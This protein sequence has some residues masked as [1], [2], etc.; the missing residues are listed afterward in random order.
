MMHASARDIVRNAVQVWTASPMQA[1][2]LTCPFF[3]V[4]FGGARGGGK[5]DA[6]LGDFLS[7]QAIYGKHAVGLV[8]RRERTQLIETIQRGAAIYELVGARW[9]DK[10]KCFQFP[11]GARLYFGYLE[12]DTDAEVYQGWS[13]TRVYVE[14]MGNFRA[15]APIAKLFATLRSPAGVPCRFRATAN[16]GGAGHGWIK[17]RFIDP[18]PSGNRRI[19]EKLINPLTGA[20]IERDRAY[21]PS[22]VT[23]NPHLGDD[24]VANLML[25]G[26][27]SAALVKAWLEGDWSAIEGAFFSEWAASRHVV[28][29]FT[30]PPHWAR[31]RAIDWG[32]ARPFSVGWYAIVSETTDLGD[33]RVMPRGSIIRYREWYG[34]RQSNGITMPNDGLRLPANEVAKQVAAMSEGEKIAYTVIDPATFA[35][36]GGQTIAEAFNING[37]PVLP[38][39]NTR[40]S[41]R[42]AMSGWNNCRRRL[43]GDDGAPTFY[44]FSTCREFI[45]TVPVLQHDRNKAEDLDSE[46]EDHAADEW[47]YAMA[48]RPWVA[49]TP[50]TKPKPMRS[51]METPIEELFRMSGR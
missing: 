17:T 46:A 47:R 44:V 13:L 48:S 8:L 12:R 26:A 34:A 41:Q 31:F 19:V 36:T 14:E 28:A 5:T 4:L 18:H 6:V 11:N 38:A 9:L 25:S 37:V 21:V 39:D 50:D 45:R 27:G 23:D 51:V 33:G 40:V 30:I 7:H 49:K 42:G 10:D 22:R 2:F 24:Y 35:N 15:F 29:P 32:T 20:A 16:P 3:E 1:R 43:N